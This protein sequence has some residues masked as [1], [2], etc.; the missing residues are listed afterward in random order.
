[1]IVWSAVLLMMTAGLILSSA[2]AEDSP[3]SRVLEASGLEAFAAEAKAD[4][5]TTETGGFFT[6][7]WSA[8][9]K[10][11][12][13]SK[14][15]E[16]GYT[17]EQRVNFGGKAAVGKNSVKFTTDGPAEVKIWWVEGGEDHRQ[18]GILN[19]EGEVV[20]QTSGEYVKNS[21]YYSELAL[22]EAG[23]YYLGGIGGNNY[24]C[25]PSHN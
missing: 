20:V 16:D 5:D 11:D 6:L 25:L 18:M 23:T 8:K 3:A 1:M 21:P 17:S 9:S 22:E 24:I 15:W 2:G 14:T 13:S 19:G 4:G 7:L 10:V 12:G